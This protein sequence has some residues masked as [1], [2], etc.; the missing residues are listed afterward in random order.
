MVGGILY[1]IN[2]CLVS[3]HFQFTYIYMYS[4]YLRDFFSICNYFLVMSW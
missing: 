1:N 3:P 2:E 4:L